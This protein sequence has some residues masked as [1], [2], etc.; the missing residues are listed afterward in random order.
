VSSPSCSLPAAAAAETP[1]EELAGR[2]VLLWDGDCGFCQRS[3]EWV[4]CRDREG[5]FAILPYQRAPSPP[6]TP[7]LYRACARAVH[8]LTRDGRTLRA[9]GASL[10]VLGEI[11]WPRAL[12]RLLALPP[13]IW[14]VAAGYWIVARNRRF[15]S[16]I[17]FRPSKE[18]GSTP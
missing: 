8:L 2:H 12:A 4:R 16:R 17:L 10:F 6:M 11:G 1:P 5:R 9:G 7:E 18:E 13:F 3:A 14:L 15:F